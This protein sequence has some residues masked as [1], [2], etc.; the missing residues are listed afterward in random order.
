M[1]QETESLDCYYEGSVDPVKDQAIKDVV[2]RYGGSVVSEEVDE[3]YCPGRYLDVEFERAVDR[4]VIAAGL[5]AT[6]CEVKWWKECPMWDMRMNCAYKGDFDP[7]KDEAILRIVDRY[8]GSA[9]GII[10]FGRFLGG[11]RE[12]FFTAMLNDYVL[13]REKLDAE[14]RTAGCSLVEIDGWGPEPP[15]FKRS[16]RAMGRMVAAKASGKA[17]APHEWVCNDVLYEF[18]EDA[19]DLH[20]LVAAANRIVEEEFAEHGTVRT[21]YV[22][23]RLGKD[24]PDIVPVP[25]GTGSDTVLRAAIEKDEIVGYVFVYQ[26]GDARVIT[27]LARDVRGLVFAGTRKIEPSSERK[28]APASLGPMHEVMDVSILPKSDP[29]AEARQRQVRH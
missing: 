4:D 19:P 6:G 26:P 29:W 27:F 15:S 13:D 8:K 24:Q 1:T 5:T 18:D 28:W 12:R 22:L 11:A 23:S 2:H 17:L 20:K 7:E 10:A 21:M 3:G 14:L 25:D 9:D 16:A